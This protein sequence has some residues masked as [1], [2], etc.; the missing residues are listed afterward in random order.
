[1][2]KKKAVD[3]M[4]P[5]L[6]EEGTDFLHDPFWMGMPA[7]QKGQTPRSIIDA[8]EER[9]EP[10]SDAA[11]AF[12]DRDD[13]ARA[14]RM[15]RKPGAGAPVRKTQYDRAADRRKDML[16]KE[17]LPTLRRMLSVEV[18]VCV[19]DQMG[20]PTMPALEVELNRKYSG[21]PDVS[22]LA[23]ILKAAGRTLR[24]GRRPKPK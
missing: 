5:A 15:K 7:P 2:T 24:R 13:A 4:P 18:I 3:A 14:A 10:I 1:M 17:A 22:R 6:P 11:R 19:F 16:R 20:E 23:K 12:A 21:V 8:A 9:G